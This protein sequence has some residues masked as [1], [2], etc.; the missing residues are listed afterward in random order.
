MDNEQIQAL[1]S[2]G[3]AASVIAVGAFF[4]I[5]WVMRTVQAMKMSPSVKTEKTTIITSDTVAMDRLAG[6]IEASNLI[7]TENNILRREEHADRS[8]QR[9]AL[10]ENTEAVERIMAV[11]QDV[12]PEIRE[13]TR[14]IVRS[15][16]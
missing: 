3:G 15:G 12:R 1:Y 8:S 11:I 14:E 6:T 4:G 10:E 7:L 2:I 16:R 5:Q 13:L 9:K